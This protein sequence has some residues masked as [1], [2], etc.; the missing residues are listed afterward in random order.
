MQAPKRRPKF[1][2]IE[3]LNVSASSHKT[4][5]AV[6]VYGKL[7]PESESGRC[8]KAGMEMGPVA[9][10]VD[11]NPFVLLVLMML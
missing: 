4:G 9:L 1:L 11:L 3:I 10:Q 7:R 2:F 5:S 6:A 8:M